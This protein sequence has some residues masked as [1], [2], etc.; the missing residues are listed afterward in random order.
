[1]KYGFI[2]DHTSEYPV[3]LLCHMLSV[4]RSAYY[5]WKAQPCKVIPPEEL[6]LRRRMKAL[7]VASRDSLGSRMMMNNLRD[8]GFEIGRDKTRRLMKVLQLKV[9]QKRKFK[10]TTDSKHNFPVA[11]NVLNREFSPSAPNQAWG[12]DITYLWTQ[13][14]WIYPAVV[15]DLYSRRVVGWSIDRRMKK[16]LVIRALIMAVNLRKPPPGLIHHSDR[17]S[18]YASHD[19]QKL[20]KQHGMI[21][22]M[23]RKG[24]CWDNAPVERF[25]SSLKREWT[26]DRWY[27]TRQEAIADVREYVAMY[28]NSKRLHSTLG[29]MTPL[30]YEKPL[31]KVSGIC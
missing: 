6:V 12:T 28:Y 7:F 4:Q 18:Q 11:R 25:F 30:N 15:I 17:G 10:V 22:S 27:R 14:G 21:C 5:N 13:E 29:Y 23:S 24:N 31:N 2:R 3:I 19:Y 26:G 20:L 8:E 9:K 1:V 16:A